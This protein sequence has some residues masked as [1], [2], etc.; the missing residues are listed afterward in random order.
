MVGKDL[1]EAE[2]KLTA[3]EQL[4]ALAV[5]GMKRLSGWLNFS[6]LVTIVLP[7]Q[8]CMVL[9]RD[10]RVHAR[11]RAYV[12]EL[13]MYG[14]AFRVAEGGCP[15][16]QQASALKEP[17]GV[18]EAPQVD[19]E[20]RTL[21]FPSQRTEDSFRVIEKSGWRVYFDGRCAKEVGSGGFIAF[22][23]H[24]QVMGGLAMHFGAQC[25]TNNAAELE[26]LYR[27]LVWLKEQPITSS[28]V[29]LLGDSSLVV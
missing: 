10:K 24:G 7:S 23:E 1:S 17:G 11:L 20:E 13:Q 9:L 6:T 29:A 19:H 26:A 15:V 5:W 4:L 22:N 28:H 8:D 14:V 18:E 25:K 3:P 16:L 27:A 2:K 12:L 21:R